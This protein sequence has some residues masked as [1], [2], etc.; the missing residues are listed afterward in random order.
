MNEKLER[1]YGRTARC[2]SGGLL[3]LVGLY[4]VTWMVLHAVT[5]THM[6]DNPSHFEWLLF[7]IIQ[8]IIGVF[9]MYGGYRLLKRR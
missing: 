7:F 5:G 4:I 1:I 3:I 8:P 2:L 6:S 9:L